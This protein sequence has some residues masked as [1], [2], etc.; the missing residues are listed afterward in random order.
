MLNI[1]KSQTEIFRK[2]LVQIKYT[3]LIIEDLKKL[4]NVNK[5]SLKTSYLLNSYI[6]NL[7]AEWQT[8]IENLLR[9]C[10]TEISLQSN[11]IVKNIL[12]INLTEKIKRF[13]NPNIENIDSSFES[14]LGIKNI[15]RQ[16][17][18]YQASRKRINEIMSIRHSIAHKG[19]SLSLL[20]MEENFEIMEFLLSVAGE[21][22]T[23]S[24]NHIK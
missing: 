4:D 6:M 10:V 16:L 9:E 2:R 1:K 5:M 19:F 8:F 15:T 12:E 21:L 13:G 3:Q 23:I 14:L 22:E 20:T 7:I 18:N 17:N 24:L 11:E